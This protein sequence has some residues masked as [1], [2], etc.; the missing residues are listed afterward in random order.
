MTVSLGV[1]LNWECGSRPLQ[2]T[3]RAGALSRS[4]T[5]SIGKDRKGATLCPSFRCPKIALFVPR[6]WAGASSPSTTK[7]VIP[8]GWGGCQGEGT[9][10]GRGLPHR[11]AAWGQ[12]WWQHTES[13]CT[14]GGGGDLGDIKRF[15]HLCHPESD[16]PPKCPQETG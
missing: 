5:H 7:C 8:R 3:L 11:V 12:R 6:V 4:R 15:H 10:Q 16:P 14:P 1:M 13:F 9:A 2:L